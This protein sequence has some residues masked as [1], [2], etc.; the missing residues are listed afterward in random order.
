MNDYYSEWERA[1]RKHGQWSSCRSRHELV[2]KYAFAIPTDEAVEKIASY[3]KLIEVGAGTG[4]WA[5]LISEAGG[6][7]LAFDIAPP[8]KEHNEYQ[9]KETFFDVQSGEVGKIAKYKDRIL[10][11]CWPPYDTRFG[12]SCL[13]HYKGDLFIYVGE[14][15][16]GC[17]G[18]SEFW[19]LLE[20][21]WEED[22]D[23]MIRLPQ[24]DGI[25]DYLTFYRRK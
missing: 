10:F 6:D 1:V 19:R 7:I 9:F 22:Y 23:E 15:Y 12:A 2:R 4:Y 3:G 5:K 20:K 16:H 21:D 8:D 17:C 25:H 11:L 24:W 14:G 13:D 18:D